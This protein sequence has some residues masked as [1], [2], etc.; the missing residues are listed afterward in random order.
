MYL[1][2]IIIILLVCLIILLFIF[3]IVAKQKIK[4][5][6]QEVKSSRIKTL[7]IQN[8]LLFVVKEQESEL[9]KCKINQTQYFYEL[10]YSVQNVARAIGTLNFN[11]GG[12]SLRVVQKYEENK[13]KN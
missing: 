12:I 5:L 2:Y 6:N 3:I 11:K 8:F 10:L 4:T 7:E 1:D 9:S 13:H